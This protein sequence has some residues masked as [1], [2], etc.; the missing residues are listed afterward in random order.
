MEEQGGV[1]QFSLQRLDF[2]S[3]VKRRTEAVRNFKLFSEIPADECEQIIAA[4]HEQRYPKGKTIFFEGDSV[5]QVILLTSGAVKLV[6]SNLNGDETIV[7]LVG[8]GEMLCFEGFINSTQCATASAIEAATA[9]VWEAGQ[10]QTARD[11]FA[12]LGRNVA[13]LLQQALTQLEVRF[14]EVSTEK[15]NLR[16]SSQLLR[17]SSQVGKPADGH[18]EIGLSQRDLAQLTGTTIFTV[19]RLLTRWETQGIVAPRR[20]A[21]RVLDMLGLRNL[22]EFND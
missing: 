10:F 12:V 9:L 4:A 6:Q 3:V 19:S 7:R 14:R 13:D 22:S 20:E 15:V 11:C 16:L 8:P 2:R 21:V 18:V 1:N 5:R 17:L